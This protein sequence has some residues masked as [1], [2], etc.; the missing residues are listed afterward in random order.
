MDPQ[1]HEEADY[2]ADKLATVIA[3]ARSKPSTSDKIRIGLQVAQFI[4]V[5]VIGTGVAW[6]GE[7]IKEQNQLANEKVISALK[8][9]ETRATQ[10]KVV[11]EIVSLL[12]DTKD[13]TKPKAAVLI[14][15]QFIDPAFALQIAELVPSQGTKAA[16]D[17][18]LQSEAAK[19]IPIAAA[20]AKA[21][22]V[23]LGR[24]EGEWKTQ[25]FDF[26]RE[27]SPDDLSREKSIIKVKSSVGRVTLRNEPMR[28][29]DPSSSQ[30]I[31][32]AVKISDRVQIDRVEP[33]LGS[34]FMWGFVRFVAP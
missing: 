24:Y 2:L 12:F 3:E 16:A 29:D 25:L 4:V 27:K 28:A 17:Q 11:Q 1:R 8:E 9:T 19:A 22:W 7:Q 26:P 30:S 20:N 32:G 21:G 5:G 10:A 31:I 18:I 34:S 6:Y 33:R 14:I 23:Y 15:K 13:E